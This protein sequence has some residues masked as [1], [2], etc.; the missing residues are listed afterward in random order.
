VKI[1]ERNFGVVVASQGVEVSSMSHNQIIE[2]DVL[3]HA[4]HAGR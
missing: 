1:K 3:S 4:P 2:K